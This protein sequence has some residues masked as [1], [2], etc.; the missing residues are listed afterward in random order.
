MVTT[1]KLPKGTANATP[2]AAYGT[3]QPLTDS[4][5]STAREYA[6]AATDAVEKPVQEFVSI[7]S[8]VASAATYASEER[9]E[10]MKAFVSELVSGKEPVYTES[11]MS[12]LSSLLYGTEAPIV[13]KA[14]SAIGEGY[15]S[16]SSIVAETYESANSAMGSAT[17][18]VKEIYSTVRD[19]L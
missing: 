9:Y 1:P 18:K 16:V 11:V 17:E 13:A 5:A 2:R 10:S 14:T 3:T 6:A 7:A 4:I 15:D 12:R 8:V 19:E